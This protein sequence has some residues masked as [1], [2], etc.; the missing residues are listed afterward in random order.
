MYE[1]IPRCLL[2]SWVNPDIKGLASRMLV[3][4]SGTRD[5]TYVLSISRGCVSKLIASYA[6]INLISRQEPYDQVQVDELYSFIQTTQAVR[7]IFL[8]I[9]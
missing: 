7:G 5:I 6:S 9:G 4:G 1:N 3:R 8:R 2:L